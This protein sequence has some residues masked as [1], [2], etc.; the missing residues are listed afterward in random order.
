VAFKY[1]VHRKPLSEC[2]EAHI[3]IR[4]LK[5]MAIDSCRDGRKIDRVQGRSI[6]GAINHDFILAKIVNSGDS[7][8]LYMCGPSCVL[9]FHHRMFLTPVAGIRKSL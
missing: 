7:C 6:E 5:S 3:Q 9:I 4:L 1:K 2:C 8:Y